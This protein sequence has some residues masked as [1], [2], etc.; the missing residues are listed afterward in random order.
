MKISEVSMFVL[1][2]ICMVGIGVYFFF[3][4]KNG[5]EKTISTILPII[6]D[7]ERALQNMQKV[8]ITV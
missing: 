5:G 1:Y 7:L 4:D 8:S 2:L 6:D 3:R